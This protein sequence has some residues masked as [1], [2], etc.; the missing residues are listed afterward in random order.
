[1]TT[2]FR[3]PDTGK[4]L[5]DD[6]PGQSGTSTRFGSALMDRHPHESTLAVVEAPAGLP[7][8]V[9]APVEAGRDLAC[10][11]GFVAKT[12]FGLKAHQRKH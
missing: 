8:A 12:P 7:V 5:G 3:D 1:M 10:H 6:L 9:A 4:V 11:C 2:R